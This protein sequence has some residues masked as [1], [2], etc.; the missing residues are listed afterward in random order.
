METHLRFVYGILSVLIFELVTC[1]AMGQGLIKKH[2]SPSDYKLW[3][4]L[5]ADKISDS[6]TWISYYLKYESHLDTLFI[7]NVV[8]N[9]E[10]AFPKGSNT[11]FGAEKIFGYIDIRKNLNIQ[12]LHT[13][14]LFS[15]PNV[16]SYEF[17]ADNRFI[18]S[19]EKKDTE[20]SSLCIRTAEG[21]LIH[22]IENVTEYKINNLRNKLLYVTSTGQASNIGQ[23]NFNTKISFVTILSG[24]PP[25]LQS[26]TWS[27]DEKSFAFYGLDDQWQLFYY[28]FNTNN[29]NNI[30]ILP[31][32]DFSMHEIAPDNGMRLKI[33]SDNDAV[34]F[35]YKNSQI[36]SMEQPVVEIWNA[37]DKLLYPQNNAA[38]NTNQ[39]YLAM[40]NPNTGKTIPV[41]NKQYGWTTLTGDQ[42]YAII[43]D[44]LE[45][46]PQYKDFADTDY[47]LM[48]LSTGKK[49]VLIENVSMHPSF[50]G[51]SP[52]GTYINYYKNK[53]WWIYDIKVKTHTNITSDL[54]TE[55]D[56]STVDPDPELYGFK[57]W[58]PDGKSV[59]IYDQFDIW[60]I[61]VDGRK[62]VRLTTGKEQNIRF[63]FADES[64]PHKAAF[65]YSGTQ[66]GTYDLNKKNVLSAENRLNGD[67]GYYILDR[68]KLSPL[69]LK[70][71]KI[72]SILKASNKDTYLFIYQ[73]FENAPSILIKAFNRSSVRTVVQSNKQQQN[74]YWGSSEMIHYAA[75]DNTL[76]NGAL[77]YPA[78]YNTSL[79][80][81]MI[82]YIYSRPS[83][84]IHDYVNPTDHN[85][86]GFN[87][88]TFTAAGYFVLLADIAYEKGNPGI[89]AVNCVTSAVKNVTTKGLIDPDKIGLL[90]HSFGAY[91]SNFI[92]TQSSLFAAA[93]SGAGVSDIIRTYFSISGENQ[94]PEIW[95]YENQQYRMRAS[96]YEDQSAYLKN[97]PILHAKQINTPLLTW[98]GKNDEN[99]K[100]EQS[101]AFYLSLRRLKKKHIML[102]YPNQGHILSSAAAQEDLSRKTIEWFDYYLKKSSSPKWIIKSN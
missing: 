51:T 26:L 49:E 31:K 83:F 90:G 17:A 81:P 63:R 101:T 80:Y 97:S 2:L 71:G 4:T 99:V 40:W 89:S 67:A 42:K 86:I 64:K 9:K 50:I 91:E 88:T 19:L 23:V 54:A 25:K 55:F 34:F 39:S 35:S 79:K 33:S 43:A 56:N 47:Y 46:E 73:S 85:G 58:A 74:F 11:K 77:Y 102:Q 84:K 32:S 96:L 87:I 12:D 41:S 10:Y 3:S 48:N 8:S 37:D 38:E 75:P 93:V 27:Q 78:N 60:Q 6:G 68:K 70:K 5:T 1:P 24:L 29:I 16:L 44:P 52:D 100:A 13:G 20:A 53:S 82:V 61:T 22:S 65:N 14:Q 94:K 45:Y 36:P 7:K 21:K 57:G 69:A 95:R 15:I 92:I 66:N 28:Q 76:L 18:V 62:R 72:N 30:K 59:L 98:T